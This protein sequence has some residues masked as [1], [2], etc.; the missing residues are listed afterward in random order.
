M[1]TQAAVLWERNSPWSVETI[2]LDPPKAQEVL[3]E[4]HASG[5]VSLRRPPRHR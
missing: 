3:V 1:Q 5:H 2:D 4:L